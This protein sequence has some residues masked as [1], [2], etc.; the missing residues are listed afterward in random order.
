MRKHIRVILVF[1]S[2]FPIVIGRRG[3]RVGD[4]D[5]H[6]NVVQGRGRPGTGSSSN[7]A[8]I[9]SLNK[10]RLNEIVDQNPALVMFYTDG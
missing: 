1:A 3:I 9:I 10:T 6:G 4:G 2:L 7:S 5:G 8:N